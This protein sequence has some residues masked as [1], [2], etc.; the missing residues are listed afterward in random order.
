MAL[1]NFNRTFANR[2]GGAQ[3]IHISYD[4][5]ASMTGSFNFGSIY[6]PEYSMS[7]EMTGDMHLGWGYDIAYEM[8][9]EL[10]GNIVLGYYFAP[11]Y[12]AAAEMTGSA[13][14]TITVMPVYDLSA[15]MIG[16][17]TAN[18]AVYPVYACEAEMTGRA[19][20]RL[21]LH[22]GYEFYSAMTGN[23]SL[24]P[25]LDTIMAFNGMTL[26][27]HGT[28]II[29]A[30]NYNILLNGQNAIDKYSGSWLFFDR[31]LDGL[32]VDSP[33]SGNINVSV[34]YRERYL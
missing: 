11:S 6:S 14:M 13:D 1:G 21:N 4:M 8:D 29:D 19:N 3:Q 26:P 10:T 15:E 20:A 7:A 16:D 17:A 22:M 30:E 31:P 34:L 24:T 9:A 23:V 28:L 18:V 12:D 27:A 32:E 2:R 5:A 25:I 33:T